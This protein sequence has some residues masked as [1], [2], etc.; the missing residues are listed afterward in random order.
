[1]NEQQPQTQTVTLKLD[2]NKL[3]VIISGLIKLPIEMGLE[4]FT[5]VQKQAQAQLGD[6]SSQTLPASALP[7]NKLN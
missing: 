6:P 7:G 5:E 1:M 3:N 2:V 4:T